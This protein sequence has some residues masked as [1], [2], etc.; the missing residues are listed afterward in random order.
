MYRCLWCVYVIYE[1]VDGAIVYVG[2]VR[3]TGRV[4]VESVWGICVACNTGYR[5][6]NQC[7]LLFMRALIE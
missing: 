4:G 1:W 7:Y 2:S 6:L 5:S 3:L